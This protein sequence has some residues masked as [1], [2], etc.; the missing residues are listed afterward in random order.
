MM[1][2]QRPALC[3]ALVKDECTQSPFTRCSP[4]KKGGKQGAR[5][6]LESEETVREN[7]M[8]AVIR[9]GGKQYRVQEGD[10]LRI[11]LLPGTEAGSDV[12]FEE[13][14]MLG[15]DSLNVG[16]P[17]VDGAKVTA[18]IVRNARDRKI[19]IFKSRRRKGYRKKRGHRQWFTQIKITGISA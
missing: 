6:L 8:Y 12:T 17:L 1:L 2:V 7:T 18:T 10:V 14:L 11:E 13:V 4:A 19:V 5:W 9:T 3:G 15:G 16:T